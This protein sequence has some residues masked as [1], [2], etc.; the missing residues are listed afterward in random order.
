MSDETHAESRRLALH[1]VH[2]ELG[3]R[4]APFAGHLMPL[5]YSGIVDEHHAVRQRVG[6]FDVSHM[7][8]FWLRGADAVAAIDRIVTN[9]IA[10]LPLGKAAY[11]VMC[12]EEGGIVDDLIIYKVADDALFI[13][14]NASRR[15][16]DFAHL[17][18]HLSGRAELTDETE[19][20]VLLAVQGPRAEATLAAIT[21]AGERL[22]DVPAFS[23][24]TTQLAGAP[25]VELFL[26]R[27]GYTGE[28]GFEVRASTEHAER[29]ARA[30]L[31]AGVAQGLKPAGLG[32]RDTLRLEARYPLYGYDITLE[33]NPLEA[34]LGW[35]VKFDKAE[36]F[37]GQDALERVRKEGVSRRLRGVVMRERGVLR[38]GYPLFVGDSRVGE[39]TSGTMSPTLGHA[40]GIAYVDRAHDEATG[41]EVE[42]RGRRLPVEL[43]KRPFYKR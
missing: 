12:V 42:I 25:E 11:T 5:Q 32:A 21:A 23:F 29:V 26:A 1:Q 18:A 20:Y 31:D 35:V 40:I 16:V 13:V 24:V 9:D 39:L 7:G 43:W 33:T 28:D 3:A 10:Q 38:A 14:V 2:E 22:S 27:T 17:S 34:G 8:N 41:V 37:V 15:E 6:L 4:F 36:R 30:I 19:S